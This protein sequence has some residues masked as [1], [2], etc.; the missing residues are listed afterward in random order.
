MHKA[1]GRRDAGK[2]IQM[3]TVIRWAKSDTQMALVDSVVK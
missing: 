3:L 2:E 1:G